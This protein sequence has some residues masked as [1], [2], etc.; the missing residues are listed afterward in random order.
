M[1]ETFAD[2]VQLGQVWE[3]G[4]PSLGQ[5]EREG[6]FFRNE[7]LVTCFNSLMGLFNFFFSVHL[8]IFEFWRVRLDLTIFE[9]VL[10]Y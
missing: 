1:R 8:R 7:I 3:G 10:E 5:G 4:D 6:V 9:F 2:V